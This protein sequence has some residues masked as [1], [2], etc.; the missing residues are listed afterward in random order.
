MASREGGNSY[1]AHLAG[2]DAPRESDLEGCSKLSD[3]SLT[4]FCE[5]FLEVCLG[6]TR[7]MD[8][9]LALGGLISRQ[10]GYVKLRAKGVAPGPGGVAASLRAEVA[11]VL[12]AATVEGKVARGEVARLIG[13]SKRTAQDVLRGLLEEGLLVSHSEHGPARRRCWPPSAL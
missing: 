1:R 9:L 2:G 6:L 5:F 10:E 7:Y 11:M 13:M 8:G 4:E 3:Q 12:C